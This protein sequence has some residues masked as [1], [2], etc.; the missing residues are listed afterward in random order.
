MTETINGNFNQNWVGGRIVAPQPVPYH[1]RGSAAPSTP[2][3]ATALALD[4]DTVIKI[5]DTYSA[6]RTV[7]E[8]TPNPPAKLQAD[9][10][11]AVDLLSEV[12][13]KYDKLS[14]DS[15][16]LVDMFTQVLHEADRV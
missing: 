2:A 11:K 4:F 8:E 16:N 7:I 13:F 12:V 3:S 5:I 9:F 15:R 14:P 6:I 10:Q 1:S